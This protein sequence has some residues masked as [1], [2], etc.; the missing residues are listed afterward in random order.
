MFD[1]LLLEMICIWWSGWLRSEW[2][3]SES[4]LSG[5]RQIPVCYLCSVKAQAV[6][7][8]A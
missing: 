2:A 1:L 3:R 4:V 5:D 7:S 6:F 8:P